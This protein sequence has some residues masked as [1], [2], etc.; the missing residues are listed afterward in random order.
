MTS[1]ISSDGLSVI[2]FGIGSANAVTIM[3]LILFVKPKGVLF[4]GK[5]RGLKKT[6]DIGHIILPTA[7]IREE[8][9]SDNYFPREVS[10]MP[11]FKLYKCVSGIPVERNIDYR[12]GVVYSTN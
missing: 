6:T 4:L 9:T 10:T 12:T 8:G 1:S 5:C 11:S 7:A 3:D 2:N